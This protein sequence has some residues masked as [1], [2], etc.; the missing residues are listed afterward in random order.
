MFAGRTRAQVDSIAAD[1]RHKEVEAAAWAKFV[2][3][4]QAAQAAPR[5][6]KP[7]E[8]EWRQGP[9]AERL[10]ALEAMALGDLSRVSPE[11]SLATQ[12]LAGLGKS[13]ST[14]VRLRLPGAPGCAVGAWSAQPACHPSTAFGAG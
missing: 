2:A 6:S 9:H 12:T 11:R 3:D 10:A 7:S 5:A 1:L 13:P 14:Q 8:A 4:V